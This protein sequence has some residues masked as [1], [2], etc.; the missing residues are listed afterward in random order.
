MRIFD[1]S[2]A[3]IRGSLEEVARLDALV[4]MAL[5]AMNVDETNWVINKVAHVLNNNHSAL[6]DTIS[7]LVSTGRLT[8]SDL[9][10]PKEER[11]DQ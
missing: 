3:L 8:A 9:L 6:L 1:S 7:M 2:D 11:N 5:Q 4:R 10:G